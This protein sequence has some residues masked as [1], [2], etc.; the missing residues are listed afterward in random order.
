MSHYGMTEE[1]VG[2]RQATIRIIS[3]AEYCDEMDDEAEMDSDL[4]W[5]LAYQRAV[6]IIQEVMSRLWKTEW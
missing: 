4:E 2:E 5:E 3:L 6:S 1:Q